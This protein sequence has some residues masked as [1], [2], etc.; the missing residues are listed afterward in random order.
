MEPRAQGHTEAIR[1]QE[2][3]PSGLPGDEIHKRDPIGIISLKH[4]ILT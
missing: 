3:P 4:L 2:N 1:G